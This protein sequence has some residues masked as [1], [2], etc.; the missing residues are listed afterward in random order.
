MAIFNV[1]TGLQVL[2]LDRYG[3]RWYQ[4]TAVFPT[5]CTDRV[6]YRLA[7]MANYQNYEVWVLL[8]IGYI[9][10]ESYITKSYKLYLLVLVQA[11]PQNPKG[12]NHLACLTRACLKMLQI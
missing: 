7:N 8:V 2:P 9:R 10:R 5:H 4:G 6:D 12:C 11:T 3:L 1:W